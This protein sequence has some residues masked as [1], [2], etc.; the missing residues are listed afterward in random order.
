MLI[1]QHVA[2]HL[3]MDAVAMV[4][5]EEYF[6]KAIGIQRFD[7]VAQ[8]CRRRLGANAEAAGKVD[9]NAVDA[10]VVGRRDEAFAPH[11]GGVAPRQPGEFQSDE[12]VGADR[13][14]RP[15]AFDDADRQQ[16][17]GATLRRGRDGR[18]GHFRHRVVKERC[19]RH[20]FLRCFWFARS[21]SVV[22]RV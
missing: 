17:D 11:P 4:A 2:D 22:D 8:E 21:R 7:D 13:Q 19:V 20:A 10:P 16:S 18:R 6:A 9:Q 14:M 1:G 12:R 3:V 5:D 15:M